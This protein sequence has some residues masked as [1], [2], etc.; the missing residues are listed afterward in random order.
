MNMVRK[1]FYLLITFILFMV[2]TGCEEPAEPIT[3]SIDPTFREFYESLGGE[4]TL[5]PAISI[6]YEEKGKKLQFTTG[7]LLMFDPFANDSQRFKLAPLGNAM[8]VAEPASGASA[9]KGHDIFPGFLAIFRQL[10][11]TRITGQPITG[12]KADPANN[13]VVQ[14]FENVGFYQ[15][16]TDPPDSAHLLYYGVWKCAQACRF[17]SKQESIVIPPSSP[18]HGIG[19]VIDRID[20]GLTGFPLS[21]VHIASDGKEEQ[22]FENVVICT[23]PGSPG[24]ISLRPL[25]KILGIRAETPLP[26]G[27]GEGKFIA[28]NGSHGFNVPNHLDEYI[29]RNKGYDFIGKPINYYDQINEDLY[30]QCFE[31]LCLDYRPS[32][33]DGLQIRPM[34]LGRRYKQDFMNE[35]STEPKQNKFEAITLT[36]WEQFPVINSEG[37]QAISAMV[38]DNGNPLKNI[39]LVMDLKLP[40][41]SQTTYEFPPTGQDGKSQI[42]VGSVDASNGTLIVYQVCIQNIPDTTSC[43]V[44]DY[45]IW[46]NP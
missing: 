22:I 32:R 18:G 11:G 41:G 20:S 45:L 33:M 24:G 8:K 30:R 42:D 36:V 29:E 23:D 27:Q 6:M 10:G 28:V 13:R 39:D 38:L 17:P 19:G 12:V 5:G 9:N 16:E 25:P 7:A 34:P 40:D 21:E 15:L 26:A 4:Q 44:D 37:E 3:K 46:G 35:I 14:Y 43:V 31:N 1:T 2:V